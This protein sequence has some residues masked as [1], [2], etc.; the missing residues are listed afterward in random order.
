MD[1]VSASGLAVG[2]ASL[3]FD[4]FDRSIKRKPIQ[5]N[6]DNVGRF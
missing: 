5:V 3:A 1:P 4:V 2:E 6:E